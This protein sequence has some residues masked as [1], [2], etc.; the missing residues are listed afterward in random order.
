MATLSISFPLITPTPQAGYRVTYWPTGIPASAI[1]ITPNPTASPV[2][3]ND[4]NATSYSGTVEA[5]CGGGNYSTPVSFTAAA[6][7][8]G[9][10]TLATGTT[11]SS[12]IGNYNLTGTVG[13]I[14]RVRLRVSGLLTPTS[15]SWL[16][17]MMGSTTPS[18]SVYGTT[19]CY[20]PGSSAGV[21][22]DLFKNITIPVGGVVNINTSIFTN[23][24]TSS[25][26]SASLT[27]MT[28][29]G[30]NNTSTGNTQISGV[31]VGNSS[32]GG[33]CPGVSYIGD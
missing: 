2:V 26:M 17:A 7:G 14:V 13:D 11:C 16:N 10:A 32:T 33:G 4:L 19:G 9:A 8:S 31:C 21:S 1:V 3:I 28:V 5:S 22:L 30:G 25:M 15:T 20:E 12:G 18:F 24:S 6:T 29:N 27:I 23:N